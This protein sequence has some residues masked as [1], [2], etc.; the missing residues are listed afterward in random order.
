MRPGLKRAIV[1]ANR[2]NASRPPFMETSLVHSPHP[3]PARRRHRARRHHRITGHPV[4]AG[5]DPGRTRAPTQQELA[6]Y[7]PAGNYLAARHAGRRARRDVGLGLLPRGAARRSEESG[8]ARAHVPL[9][10]DRRRR[11]RGGQARRA[12]RPVRQDPSRRA[13]R[14]RRAR[15]Q[16]EAVSGGA[17]AHRAVGAR[18]DRRPDRDAD[19]R[20]DAARLAAM[21]RP[22]SRASTAS[23]ARSGTR[24]S[25]TC[26]PG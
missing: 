3:A 7:S 8:A 17:P 15:A 18:P 12:R 10:P 26:M 13:A 11:R 20:L 23:P 21:S 16:A 5:D 22:R 4:R 25:R 6:R 9:R 1:R 19:H 2:G 24:S 14:A